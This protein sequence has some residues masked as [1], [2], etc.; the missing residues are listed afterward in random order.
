MLLRVLPSLPL[1][2]FPVSLS[3]FVCL[4]VDLSLLWRVYL[5]ALPS[6]G[7][8]EFS[9]VSASVILPVALGLTV[10]IVASDCSAVVVSA[11]LRFVAV[12]SSLCD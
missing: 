9:L 7:K 5:Y 10:Y 1:A 12:R 3:L 8:T 6:G 11:S 4:R 2:C